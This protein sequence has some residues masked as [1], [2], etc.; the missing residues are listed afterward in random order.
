SYAK[1]PAYSE[2]AQIFVSFVCSAY[3]A[4]IFLERYKKLMRSQVRYIIHNQLVNII[5]L[6]IHLMRPTFDL[7]YAKLFPFY[8]NDIAYI[9]DIIYSPELSFSFV[10]HRQIIASPA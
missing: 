6:I 1:S 9:C 5:R 8:R 2:V 4:Y 3:N 7:K 10:S